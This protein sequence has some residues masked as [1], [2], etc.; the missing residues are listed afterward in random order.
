MTLQTQPCLF[1]GRAVCKGNVVITN[2]IEEMDFL[3]FEEESGRNRVNG[4]VA[5]SLIEKATVLIERVEI[6]EVR[7]RSQPVQAANLKVGPL[8]RTPS[9][10]RIT[11]N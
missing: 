10:F 4:S 1:T 7:V 3:L 11:D 9:A 2:L 5:P 8:E 6:F